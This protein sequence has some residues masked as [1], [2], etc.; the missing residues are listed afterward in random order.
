MLMGSGEELRGKHRSNASQGYRLHT[1][2]QACPFPRQT[3]RPVC[4]QER[5]ATEVLFG[6]NGFRLI[7]RLTD[8]GHA[9]NIVR[10]RT[11]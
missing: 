5:H 9:R 1:N 11:N 10:I 3:C 2:V 8:F 4:E 7:G 6:K